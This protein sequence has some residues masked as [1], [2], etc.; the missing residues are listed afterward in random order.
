D[1]QPPSH[2][3][4]M[5]T[6]P[7]DQAQFLEVPIRPK[8][9]IQDP[10]GDLP[11][12]SQPDGAT[13]K[14]QPDPNVR[15]ENS[16]DRNMPSSRMNTPLTTSGGACVS[17]RHMDVRGWG[18]AN[19]Q[20]ADFAALRK[21]L[22]G[23][24]DKPSEVA[25]SRLA[26]AY[27]HAG[28][29]AEAIA[30]LSAFD[31]GIADAAILQDMG[32]LL[33]DMPLQTAFLETQM[34]CET[35]AAIWA[36][37]A[38]KHLNPGTQIAPQ[39]VLETFSSLPAHL[40]ILLGPRL[41]EKLTQA[42]NLAAAT[43]IRNAVARTSESNVDG[44]QLLE[45]RLELA[46]GHEQSALAILTDLVAKDEEDAPTA[47]VEI[48]KVM[49]ERGEDIDNSTLASLSALA[50]EYRGTRVGRDLV[51]VSVLAR[52]KA[53]MFD[54]AKRELEDI[55]RDKSLADD[56][57]ENLISQ[58]VSDV[59]KV[60]S[61]AEFMRQII[62]GGLFR[63][64]GSFDDNV[65]REIAIRLVSL[66]ALAE[67]DSFLGAIKNTISSDNVILA[68]TA[69]SRSDPDRALDLVKS[70][71]SKDARSLRA[72]AFAAKRNF[73]NAFSELQP[74]GDDARKANFA[75]LSG[76]WADLGLVGGP[77]QQALAL[78]AT[79]TSPH[80][81]VEQNRPDSGKVTIASAR[82]RIEES[83]TIRRTVEAILKT[84]PL[85]HPESL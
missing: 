28:L 2:T 82:R 4:P 6:P 61:D 39:A 78:I 24:F 25:I 42:G 57:I 60:A 83:E 15:T 84:M 27:L 68:K 55:L 52:S 76:S 22:V 43:A 63:A 5:S 67:A 10:A 8:R 58:V 1:N 65:R 36:I 51:K 32:R 19:G 75:W 34:G 31:L 80:D 14:E 71:T 56:E 41:S 77:E 23:E 18:G 50:F 33:D 9:G 46:R 37:L 38:R 16:M 45:A 85:E 73:K 54:I 11:E 59:T 79:S 7:S 53:E 26:K 69:L 47:L 30:T 72:D 17:S 35:S 81:P 70:E 29:G 13:E 44:L 20:I 74:M 12:M 48:A 40:R 3:G 66:G 62:M 64:E 49:L 21:D